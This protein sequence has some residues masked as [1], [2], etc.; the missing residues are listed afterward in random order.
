MRDETEHERTVSY[1]LDNP[2][3]WRPDEHTD[4]AWPNF[5]NAYDSPQPS[6]PIASGERLYN[7]QSRLTTAR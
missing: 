1:I 2:L 4:D 3:R 6:D 5:L 7:A